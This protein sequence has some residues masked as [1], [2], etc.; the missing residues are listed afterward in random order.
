[1][2]LAGPDGAAWRDA[3]LAAAGSL[4]ITLDAYVVGAAFLDDPHG[5]FQDAYGISPSGAV[6]VR[7]D[8]FTGWRAAS[9]ADDPERL[10]QAALRSLLG[11]DDGTP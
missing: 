2:L 7:P 9:L 1:V 5:A 3:A 4:E 10:L 6:L 8:G 11:R